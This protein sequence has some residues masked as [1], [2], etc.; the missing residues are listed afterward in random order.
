MKDNSF[1]YLVVFQAL[2]CLDAVVSQKC[3]DHLLLAALEF[4]SSLGKIFV[5]PESQVI[6][7]RMLCS[8]F[9]VMKDVRKSLTGPGH[10][11]KKEDPATKK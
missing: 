10:G 9:P 11:R 6:Q 5:P 1:N 7:M 2:L 4:L 3:A 8:R